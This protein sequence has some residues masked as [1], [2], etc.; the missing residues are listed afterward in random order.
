MN[1]VVKVA[2]RLDVWTAVRVPPVSSAEVYA[3]VNS[4]LCVL[5]VSIV[6]V[7][8]FANTGISAR[9]AYLV[10]GARFVNTRVYGCFVLYV[11]V[12][13]YVRI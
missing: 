4:A 6:E 13:N 11:K 12:H 8:A 10:K 7:V 5:T 1:L 3:F 2:K 9:P